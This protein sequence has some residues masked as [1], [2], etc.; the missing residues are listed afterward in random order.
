[1]TFCIITHNCLTNY[2]Q[3][4][5]QAF[6]LADAAATSSCIVG[7]DAYQGHTVEYKA[8]SDIIAYHAVS[9]RSKAKLVIVFHRK[10]ICVKF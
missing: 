1:M 2:L 9:R 5:L 7:M 3:A 8:V 4:T 6:D 10:P